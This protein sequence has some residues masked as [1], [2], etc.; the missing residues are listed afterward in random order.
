MSFRGSKGKEHTRDFGFGILIP[1]K[2]AI[3][4]QVLCGNSQATQ[5]NRL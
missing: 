1:Y 4:A 2:V 3:M 5:V